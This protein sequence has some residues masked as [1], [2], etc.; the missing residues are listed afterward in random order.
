M[1]SLL[2]GHGNNSTT[3]GGWGRG[4]MVRSSIE[5]WFS[6]HVL[7][8]LSIDR[9]MDPR[10][11]RLT[12]CS[13]LRPQAGDGIHFELTRLTG[14]GPG[15]ATGRPIAARHR[16]HVG[17]ARARAPCPHASGTPDEA[18]TVSRS[19]SRPALA[20]VEKP[21]RCLPPAAARRRQRIRHTPVS[22]ICQQAPVSATGLR[23]FHA[24]DINRVT[25]E[26]VIG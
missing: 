6:R 3:W 19:R 13:G 5:H 16:L 2:T 8:P 21:R 25:G 1:G 22:P 12:S 20:Y 9:S 23:A 14:P 7:L 15:T 17:A 11:P 18:K 26:A 24:R 4:S 10:R